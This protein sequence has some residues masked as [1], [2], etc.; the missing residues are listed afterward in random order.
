[1]SKI[2]EK[3]CLFNILLGMGVDR[4]KGGKTPQHI[5]QEKEKE[6]EKKPS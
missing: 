3:M 5:G 2:T 1:M 6:Q 4:N